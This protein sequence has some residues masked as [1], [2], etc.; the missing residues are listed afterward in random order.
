[1]IL[2]EKIEKVGQGKNTLGFV[3]RRV[4]SFHIVTAEKGVKISGILRSVGS[5]HMF[6]SCAPFTYL[7]DKVS[8]FFSFLSLHILGIV[9]DDFDQSLY[10]L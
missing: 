1:M 2:R 4:F 6:D 7:T 3:S 9:T 8:L 10:E 5:Y